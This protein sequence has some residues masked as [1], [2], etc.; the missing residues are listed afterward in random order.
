MRLIRQLLSTTCDIGTYLLTATI[1]SAAPGCR[2]TSH[3][4]ETPI[5]VENQQRLPEPCWEDQSI[6]GQDSLSADDPDSFACLVSHQESPAADLRVQNLSTRPAPPDDEPHQDLHQQPAQA[7]ETAPAG[8]SRFNQTVS[9]VSLSVHDAVVS[10]VAGSQ[11]FRRADSFQST[12][13]PLLSAPDSVATVFDHPIDQTGVLY[14]QRS[15]RAAETDFDCRHSLSATW[16]RDEQVQNNRFLSGGLLPGQTLSDESAVASM[17]LDKR[18]R[19]G[20]SVALVQKW[21][22]S[23][24]NVV[25]RLFTSVYTGQVRAELRQPLW[26]GAGTRFTSIAGPVSTALDGV[27][28]V[29]QGVVVAAIREKMSHLDAQAALNQMLREV[30]TQYWQVASAWETFDTESQVCDET[31]R[32]LTNVRQRF[33]AGGDGGSLADLSRFESMQ[34]DA[35]IRRND[36]LTQLLNEEQNLRR[37]MGWPLHASRPLIRPLSGGVAAGSVRAPEWCV[38]QALERRPELIRQRERVRSLRLQAEAAHSLEKPRLDFVADYH[39]NGFGDHLIDGSD[40]DGRTRQG[41]NSAWETI[42]QGNQSGWQLGF[43]Y[44]Q[45]F[46]N[47]LAKTQR[48]NLERQAA[49]ATALLTEQETEVRH[50]IQAALRELDRIEFMIER[51]LAQRQER[52]RLVRALQQE[53]HSTGQIDQL[54]ELLVAREGWLNADRQLQVSRHRRAAAEADLAWRMGNA[55]YNHRIIRYST[56]ESTP[57]AGS[58]HSQCFHN[59][60]C[61]DG[62]LGHPILQSSLFQ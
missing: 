36:A 46:G 35:E 10:A 38:Q 4:V 59:H 29:E 61:F 45:P 11:V 33:E 16:A 41:F 14:G 42:Q 26:A 55:I 37:L 21:N 22:Y 34:I 19:T 48:T 23:G 43:Q 40:I 2:T 1:L 62:L 30:V 15:V 20:G 6:G 60:S 8:S 5:P 24:S 54:S 58:F 31:S 44:Q 13:N 47:H 9:P 52:L 50:E 53:Y 7:N 32:T 57:A 18:L 39:V 3:R 28:G 12:G 17:R 51:Q 56:Q 25:D 49:R 27:T